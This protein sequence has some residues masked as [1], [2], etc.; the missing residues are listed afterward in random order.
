MERPA[1][2][3]YQITLWTDHG[4]AFQMQV[5]ESALNAFMKA[6]ELHHLGNHKKNRFTSEIK[7][8]DQ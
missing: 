3:K 1:R 8:E 5:F 6:L 2:K 4:S 7:E